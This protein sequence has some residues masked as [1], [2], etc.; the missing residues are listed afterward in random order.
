MQIMT[1]VVQQILSEMLVN[2]SLLQ[3]EVSGAYSN[4]ANTV[5]LLHFDGNFTDS[6]SNA[7]TFTGQ[8]L[9]R[10]FNS[11]KKS[12]VHNLFYLMELINI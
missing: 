11:Y 6:S 5:A 9:Y 8:N 2:I 3:H 12:L 4:D 7:T 1:V 10:Y